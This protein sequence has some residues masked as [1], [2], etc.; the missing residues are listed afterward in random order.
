MSTADSPL[1]KLRAEAG[2][3]AHKLKY[4]LAHT[5]NQKDPIKVGL[6]MDD[7]TMVIEFSLRWLRQSSEGRIRR[8]IVQMMLTRRT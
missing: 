5:V 7:K 2:K 6:V 8:R 1:S 3:M 4:D